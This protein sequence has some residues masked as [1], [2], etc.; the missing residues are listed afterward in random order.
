MLPEIETS[1]KEILTEEFSQ[2][3]FKKL[4]ETIQREY[5]TNII[6]PD[7]KN[8]FT[9][10]NLCSFTEVKVVI[11]GQ[12]PYHGKNQAHGLAFSVPKTTKIPPSLKNIFKEI[13]SDLNPD[14]PPSDGNLEHWTKQ[15]V[16]LLNTTLTV[17]A[18]KPMSHTGLGWETFTD[19]VIK[20]I[21]D[22]KEHVVFLLWGKHAQTKSPL[23]DGSKHLILKAPHPSPFSAHK[24]FLGCKHFS[25][26]NQF[27]IKN[28]QTPIDW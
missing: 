6:Y 7:F 13:V 22:L 5:Q 9:A 4:S 11:L 23:I 12:D 21:S 20:T 27:L 8:I 15:G 10:F 24:G 26:T 14:K 18:N 16:L 17:S 25:Q 1:W 19:T 2:P 3:Y 28:N